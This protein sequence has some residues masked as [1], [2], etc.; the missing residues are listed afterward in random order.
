LG[1]FDATWRRGGFFLARR[2]HGRRLVLAA[3]PR[4]FRRPL[5]ASLL[6][7]FNLRQDLV[8]NLARGRAGIKALHQAAQARA[9]FGSETRQNLVGHLR[10]QVL[11][12]QGPFFL[13]GERLHEHPAHGGA[14]PRVALRFPWSAY[15]RSEPGTLSRRDKP[16]GSLGVCHYA[17][18]RV[19]DGG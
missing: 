7:L 10:R 8:K 9:A 5:L 17:A 2:G 3:R 11:Q 16:G 6:A 13:A 15:K 19:V 14:T 1:L 18:R 12:D 4:R